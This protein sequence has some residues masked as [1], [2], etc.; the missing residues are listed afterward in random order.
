MNQQPNPNQPNMNQQPN[1]N[2]N[3]SSIGNMPQNVAALLAYLSSAIFSFI[4]QGF[5][6]FV[7]P[8]LFLLLEKNNMFVKRHAAQSLALSI[9]D[10]ILAVVAQIIGFSALNIINL[11]STN[12]L[13]TA[14]VSTGMILIFG[15]IF[16]AVNIVLLVFKII[17]MVKA[18]KNLDYDIPLIGKI[19]KSFI[20]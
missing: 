18:N 11:S 19:S 5:F 4:G 7:G 8:L 12:S 13:T 3:M 2:P 17:A 14:A 6:S 9:I 16:F 20:K 1:T 10:V 15:L